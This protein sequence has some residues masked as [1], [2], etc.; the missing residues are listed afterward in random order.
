MDVAPIVSFEDMAHD[1]RLEDEVVQRAER[2]ER[3]CDHIISCRVAIA[4]PNKHPSQGSG[5]RV[6]VEV[7]VPPRHE[8]V[9]SRDSSQGHVH[10]DAAQVVREAFRAMEERVRKLRE[11]QQ[12]KVKQ[13]PE[14]QVQAVVEQLSADHGFLRTTD[15]RQIYFHRNSVVG[16]GFAALHIGRGVAFSE[17][18][19]EQGPQ[20]STVRPVQEEGAPV[21]Q[22]HAV[23]R[24]NP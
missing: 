9:T 15:G 19:G 10:Q 7:T 13:H 1:P 21:S 20:A 24:T 5:Y 12:D 4:R 18:E 3:F 14:Q 2:L 6:R 23:D 8:L 22:H 16:P 17:E 11:Q